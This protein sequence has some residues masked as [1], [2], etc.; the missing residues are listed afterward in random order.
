MKRSAWRYLWKSE[1]IRKKLLITIMLLVI[2]RIAAN[3]SSNL[4]G[5]DALLVQD[6]AHQF[7]PKRRG[8]KE[9]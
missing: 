6:H 3:N 7:K 1:D 2:Y 8:S 4:N 5:G 9:S